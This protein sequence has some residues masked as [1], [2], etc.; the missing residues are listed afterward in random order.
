MSLRC[1]VLQAKLQ[2]SFSMARPVS[3]SPPFSNGGCNDKESMANESSPVENENV[4][5]PSM[6]LRHHER[7]NRECSV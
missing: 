1:R 6:L 4:Q 7:L 2:M 3:F 5:L